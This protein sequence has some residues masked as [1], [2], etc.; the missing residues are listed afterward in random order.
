[1]HLETAPLCSAAKYFRPGS[2]VNAQ[3]SGATT[4]VWPN[5]LSCGN[6]N[7]A[8]LYDGFL[9]G[10]RHKGYQCTVRRR[11]DNPPPTGSTKHLGE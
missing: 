5:C 8:C 11:T 6:C 9:D 1:M 3:T 10:R 4:A 7:A 2:M